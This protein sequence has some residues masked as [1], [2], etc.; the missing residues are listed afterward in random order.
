[1]VISDMSTI[2]IINIAV[3]YYYCPTDFN[4]HLRLDFRENF[5]LS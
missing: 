1:M 5:K 2:F 3:F 4:V